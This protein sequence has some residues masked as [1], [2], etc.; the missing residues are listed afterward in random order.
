MK[1]RNF[2]YVVLEAGGVIV[3]FAAVAFALF[4]AEGYR[5]DPGENNI[6]KKGVIFLKSIDEGASFLLD[7]VKDERGF[8]RGVEVLPGSHSI[9]IKKAGYT[10]WNKNIS[11]GE[12]EIARFASIMLLPASV[13]SLKT[14]LEEKNRWDFIAENDGNLVL[15]SNRM[16]FAKVYDL[17]DSTSRI[18]DLKFNF[19]FKKIA[20]VGD[21]AF[22]GIGGDGR[23][24]EYS[25]KNGVVFLNNMNINDFFY[26]GQTIFGVDKR[27]INVLTKNLFIENEGQKYKSVKL[28][29]LDE[30]FGQLENIEKRGNYI[31]L[32]GGGISGF[33]I[34]YDVNGN[35]IFES[36]NIDAAFI[37]KDKLFYA[38]NGQI[39][40]K[41]LNGAH[42]DKRFAAA[43]GDTEKIYRVGDTYHMIFLTEG[44]EMMFCDE[45]AGNCREI[46]KVDSAK[47]MQSR[48]GLQFVAD[49]EGK[50]TIFT[51][52][53][54][55]S[56]PEKF[57]QDLVSFVGETVF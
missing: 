17:S 50:F 5:Y 29:E 44:L 45:D 31:M 42:E 6:V 30:K 25:E 8:P 21:E 47:M 46:A 40:V 41:D 15:I 18:F 48:E 3:F 28:L 10:D 32:S 33:L 27:E 14:I 4:F 12:D 53:A 19:P 55:K 23:A 56:F 16:H 11:I 24:F 9:E 38:Q 57:F 49:Q 34:V 43:W 35:K 51:F 52:E 54:Q 1:K 2:L 13:D 20:Y 7:G 39:V 26:S 36:E 22:I 37:E